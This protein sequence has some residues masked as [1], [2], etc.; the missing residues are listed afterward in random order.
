MVFGM[1]CLSYVFNKPVEYK[2]RKKSPLMLGLVLV[3]LG[4]GGHIF[5]PL[6]LF[7]SIALMVAGEGVM[8]KKDQHE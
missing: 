4:A 6:L 5:L 3:A 7:C 8:I 1:G 2:A